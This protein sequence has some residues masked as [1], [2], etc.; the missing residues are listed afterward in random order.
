[1]SRVRTGARHIMS[2]NGEWKGKAILPASRLDPS[3]E[4][5]EH[6]GPGA[7]YRD[8]RSNGSSWELGLHVCGRYLE[9]PD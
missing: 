9:S 8:G 1:M 3:I 6:A 5:V 2:T 7:F 4:V